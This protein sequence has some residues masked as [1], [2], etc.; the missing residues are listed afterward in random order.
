M[1]GL[2]SPTISRRISLEVG[3]WV[4]P[5]GRVTA[6]WPRLTTPGSS[7]ARLKLFR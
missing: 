4:G 3:P 1:L 6:S 7:L 5:R 2:R